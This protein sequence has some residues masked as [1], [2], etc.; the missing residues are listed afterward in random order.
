MHA[1]PAARGWSRA[2][3]RFS[4]AFQAEVDSHV[5]LFRSEIPT[6]VQTQTQQ[7]PIRL[8]SRRL[9]RAG[10]PGRRLCRNV[11]GVV[12]APFVLAQAVPRMAGVAEIGLR[13]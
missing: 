1:H 5:W 10:A 8:E 9:V 3:Q 11:R 4:S 12:A 2:R 7:S 6:V 13:G